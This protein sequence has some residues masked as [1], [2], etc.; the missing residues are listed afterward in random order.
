[1]M[2]PYRQFEQARKVGAGLRTASPRWAMLLLFITLSIGCGSDEKH[3]TPSPLT[4]P[5]TRA[6]TLTW[7]PINLD[8][9]FTPATVT[10]DRDV[11]LDLKIS[12]PEHVSVTIPPL[13]DRL[14]GLKASGQYEDEPTTRDGATT[15]V[16]HLRLTPQIADEYRLAPFPVTYTDARTAPPVSGWFPTR[17]LV[18]ESRPPVEGAPGRTLASDP[19]PLHIRPPFRT[20]AGYIGLILLGI[21]ILVALWKLTRRVREEVQL[22]RLSPKERALRELRNL[23]AKDLIARGQVKDF[24]LELTMIVRRYIERRHAIRAPEQTTEE[25]LEAVSRDGRFTADVLTRL[26]AFLQA[27]DMVKFAA[28]QPSSDAIGHATST[29]EAYIASES[30]PSDPAAKNG[31]Q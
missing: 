1:M 28:H 2:P 3:T 9:T 10:I 18:L 21:G 19:Q 8:F 16:L 31:R 6:E 24:Y 15:R 25:F 27:A 17:P 5:Q 30:D 26:R 22:R 12:A 20:V 13:D 7:G 11:L 4:P 29:A 14:T 23:L